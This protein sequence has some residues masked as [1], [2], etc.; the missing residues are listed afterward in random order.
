MIAHPIP[1][2]EW[3]SRTNVPRLVLAGIGLGAILGA[4][5]CGLVSCTPATS[6][7]RAAAPT[8]SEVLHRVD[9]G[10]VL[11]CAGRPDR[12]ACLGAEA[13]STAIDL[14]ADKAEA[15]ARAAQDAM[16]GA[17]ADDIDE[18]EVAAELD[19]A[20]AELAAALAGETP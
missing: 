3:P 17:G 20:L 15:A 18:T 10:R 9:V 16:S 19:A 12:W 13:A 2:T 7:A 6:A 5:V 4:A 14:A 11:E 8:L 1:S